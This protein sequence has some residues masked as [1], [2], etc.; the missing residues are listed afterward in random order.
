MRWQGRRESDN[1]EDR[2]NSSSPMTGGRGLRLPAGK[3]GLV[4]LVIVV[5]ASYYGVD[6]TG[7]ISGGA[8]VSQQTSRSI[9]PN[10][11]EAAKFTS[12]ILAT[13]EESWGQQFQKMGR[14]Y[15]DPKLV[16]YR[17]ATR[18]GCGTGQSVM[19]PFYCPAD[20]T[21]YIDLSF[22]DEMKQK[23]GADGDFAQGYVIAHEVGHHV[24]KL[25]GIEPKVRQLQQ[26][27]S[28]T[29]VNRLSVR[30]ELQA[31]CFAGVWGNAMQKEGVLE[32]GDLQE[33]LN[34]AQAIGDDR[35]QQ[36][37]Q[38]RVVPDSFTHGTSDQRYSWFKRG[39]D[40]GDPAQCNTFGNAL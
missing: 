12:V 15:Q 40:S 9:S 6:L 8:P 1:V 30:L 32:T 7:L 22:Y 25:L 2:R 36:Q 23:L 28:Q 13:T 3:G 37:S 11:D 29:E 18:T 39:F 27:A 26:N 24:Q 20:S 19:G 17:G 5:V 38:G 14:T 10:E 34:A 21:V 33:A 31:D 35:L 4:L 16:M